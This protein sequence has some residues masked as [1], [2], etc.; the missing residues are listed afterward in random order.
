MEYHDV[1]V[2][3]LEDGTVEI[4]VDGVKGKKCL[5]ITSQI[6][7]LLGGEIS[8]RKLKTAYHDSD[9]KESDNLLTSWN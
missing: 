4:D 7:Q 8:E 1:K 6:E 2:K 9:D 3:I 5:A